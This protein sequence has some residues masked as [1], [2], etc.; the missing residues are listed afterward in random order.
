[1]VVEC[2]GYF[3]GQDTKQEYYYHC[4]STTLSVTHLAKLSVPASY[5]AD[6]IS[7]SSTGGI[8]ITDRFR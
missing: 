6:V 8:I 4:C 7:I 3:A 2:A 5:S 1:M